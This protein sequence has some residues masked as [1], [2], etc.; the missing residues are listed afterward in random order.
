MEVNISSQKVR[1][2]E[3]F[4]SRNMAVPSPQTNVASTPRPA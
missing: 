1:N 2:I 4:V 3:E